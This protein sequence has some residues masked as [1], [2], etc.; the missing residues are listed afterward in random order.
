MLC[1][2]SPQSPLRSGSPQSPLR[3]GRPQS[4]LRSWSPQNPLK[5]PLL[6]SGGYLLHPGGI[7]LCWPCLGLLPY[8]PRPGLLLCLPRPCLLC[9]HPR[10][11]IPVSLFLRGLYHST[12][13]AYRPYPRSTSGAPHPPYPLLSIVCPLPSCYLI[14]VS[15]APP[16]SP[17]LPSFVSLFSLLVSVVLCCHV[18]VL[19]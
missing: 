12:V 19:C 14:I 16:V 7:L 18:C 13:L 4:P 2:G 10:P 11:G 3:S 6:S 8:R 1:S 9:C 17:S 5:K 15:V